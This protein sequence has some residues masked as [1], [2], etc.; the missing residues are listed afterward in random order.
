MPRRRLHGETQKRRKKRQTRLLK[1]K[2]TIVRAQATHQPAGFERSRELDREDLTFMDAMR[3]LEVSRN[4]WSGES[5]DRRKAV[6]AVQFLADEQESALFLDRMAHL[7]INSLAGEGHGPDRPARAAE[8]TAGQTH[9]GAADK[10]EAP[11]PAGAAAGTGPAQASPGDDGG[12][13]LARPDAGARAGP[14][15]APLA[16]PSVTTLESEEPAPGLFEALL[17]ETPFQPEQKFA[18]AGAPARPRRPAQ[19]LKDEQEPDSELD[20]HGKTQEEAIRMVQN[21]LL[22]SHRQRL[23]HVLIITGKGHHSGDAGPVLKDTVYRW[24]ER[25]GGRFVRA[26]LRAP[27]RHGG[28]GAIWVTLR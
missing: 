9:R 10:S 27:A 16:A 22:V 11:P 6:E 8:S 18:G 28:D 12:A 23:R 4:P 13:S 3:E 17:D 7:G 25:N 24:L 26:I 5:P 2:D 19:P 14:G 20:L 21:V 15:S 1:R